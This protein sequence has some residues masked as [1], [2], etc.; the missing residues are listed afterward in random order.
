M[1]THSTVG[2]I[3]LDD[4]RVYLEGIIAGVIGAATIAIWFLILDTIDSR[5]LY[6]PSVLGTVLFGGGNEHRLRNYRFP[7]R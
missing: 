4:S 5:P 7:G 1:L 6:T 2:S 3:T